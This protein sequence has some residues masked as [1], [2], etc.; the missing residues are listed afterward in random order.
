MHGDEARVL[1]GF[2]PNY[3]PT[4]SQ[5]KAAYRRKV[6]ESH[7]DLFPLDKKPHA[8]SKFKLVSDKLLKHFLRFPVSCF[9]LDVGPREHCFK[10]QE[11]IWTLSE[12]TRSNF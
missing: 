3:R 7:P 9:K 11:M 12:F 6:W 10:N 1:L 4:L 8:E 2:P 5:V